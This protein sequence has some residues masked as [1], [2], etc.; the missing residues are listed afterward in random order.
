MPLTI[1]VD[2]DGTCCAHDFPNIGKNIGAVEVLHEIQR[3]GHRII[4]WTVRS[5][6]FLH[7]A[8]SWM[9]EN[10]IYPWGVNVN[11]NQAGW[12]R[13]PKAHADFFIDD[14]ALGCPLIH[15]E[16]EARPYVDWVKMRALLVTAGVLPETESTHSVETA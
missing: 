10:Q 15:E 11:P 2:F 4:L 12:S 1:A 13:S 9:L 16:G 14:M 7:D 3:Q 6:E 8:L 5:E